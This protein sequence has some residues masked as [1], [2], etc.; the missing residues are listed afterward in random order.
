M[1]TFHEIRDPIHNFIRMD[2][3]ERRVLN[4][5][6][7]QRLRHIHQLGLSHFVYPGANHSRLEHSLG[8]MELASRIF[9]VVVNTVPADVRTRLPELQDDDQKAYWRR[10]LRMAALCHDVGHLPFSHVAEEELL[11]GGWDHERLT[12]ELILSDEMKEIWS[13]MRPPLIP[14]DIVKLAIGPRKAGDLTY[15]P[16]EGILSEIIVGDAF[17]ADRMDYLLRD[18]YHAGVAYGRFD[19]YRL[20]DTLRILPPPPTQGVEGAE[21]PDLGVEVGGV[22]S[23][24]ALLLARYFMFTQVYFHPVRRIYDIHLRDFLSEWLAASNLPVDSAS[25]LSMT[26]NEVMSAMLRSAKDASQLGHDPANRI[27]TRNHFR[28]LYQRYP[29][30]NVDAV[31]RVF[32]AARAHFG[33][34]H[35][36]YDVAKDRARP[37]DFPVR[38]KDGRIAS[39][40][41]LSMVLNVLPVALEEYVFIAPERKAEGSKWL[42]KNRQQLVKPVEA[43]EPETEVD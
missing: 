37:I 26:D 19:H 29:D 3:T 1:V 33:K 25:L 5:R 18:S 12:R 31:R 38:M 23:A 14:E 16:W 20:V 42:E 6:P 2:S 43:D 32:E 40:S 28:L 30:E 9:D 13:T 36:R 7:L 17:G 21:G 22:H 10:V 8:V 4:S 41:A 39:A 27:L 15:S 11:P 35:V 34:E 24:E